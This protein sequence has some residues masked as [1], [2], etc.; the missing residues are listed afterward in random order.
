MQRRRRSI[1]RVRQ[2][3]ICRQALAQLPPDVPEQL[4]D[5]VT[6]S[7]VALID[8]VID[9]IR[10]YQPAAADVLMEWTRNFQ[11]EAMLQVLQERREPS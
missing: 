1:R 9:A 3:W 2:A 6:H 4:R 8:L 11:Y 10:A 7:D 5:A